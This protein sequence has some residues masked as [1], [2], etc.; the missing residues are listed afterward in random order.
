ML[1]FERL[2]LKHGHQISLEVYA[3]NVLLA[4][5]TFNVVMSFL[6][7]HSASNLYTIVLMASVFLYFVFIF[8]SL[9]QNIL[10]NGRTSDSSRRSVSAAHWTC[11]C[12][13]LLGKC[14]MSVIRGGGARN[15]TVLTERQGQFEQEEEE[16]KK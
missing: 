16:G 15:R 9:F 10:C 1:S 2:E 11:R 3:P 5:T 14:L 13:S 8:S 12:T 7:R 4:P 6:Y